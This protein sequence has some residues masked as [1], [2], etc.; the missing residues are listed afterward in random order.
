MHSSNI[1]A[2]LRKVPKTTDVALSPKRATT[3]IEDAAIV[4]CDPPKDLNISL[5]P[6]PEW[7]EEAIKCIEKFSGKTISPVVAESNNIIPCEEILPHSLDK[8]HVLGDG[9]CLFRALEKEITGSQQS[10]V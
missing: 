5:S 3:D 2:G 6:T 9:N 4:G 1:E 8:I 7:R 10:N